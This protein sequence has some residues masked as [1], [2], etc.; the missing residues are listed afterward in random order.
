MTWDD[1]FILMARVV[2]LKSKDS[3]KV[4]AVV[5]D[6][7]TKVLI[8]VGFNGLPRRMKDDP[9]IIARRE[10]PPGQLTK[11]TAIHAEANAILF[12]QR[13]LAG[14]TIYTTHRPCF[15]CAKLIAASGISRVVYD[16]S[17]ST[18]MD[19]RNAEVD[20]LFLQ[21]NITLEGITV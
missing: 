16:K 9:E 6:G 11:Y 17:T 7:T 18:T 14:D 8:S 1:Y 2:A 20:E 3:T 12:A 15:E 4:G 10:A 13:D 5:V 19:T 21:C